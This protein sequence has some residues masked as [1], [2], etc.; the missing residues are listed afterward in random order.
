MKFR[1]PGQ[2]IGFLGGGQL[3][4]MMALHAHQLGFQ[5]H[6]LCQSALEPAAQVTPHWHQGYPNNFEDLEKFLKKIDF[7]TCESEF[8]KGDVLKKAS[9]S[10]KAPL[11]PSPEIMSEL[12]DRWT[13]KKS[14]EEF[15][16]PTAPFF[17]INDT[18][19]FETACNF[20]KHKLVFKK[21]HGGYDGNGTYI[22]KSKKNK[23]KILTQLSE[24]NFHVI[25]EAFIPFRRELA[26]V[27]VR[28]QFGAILNLPL[29]ETYQKNSRCDWVRGPAKHG[30]WV[31]IK[32]RIEAWLE[33]KNYVGAIA[34]EFFDTGKNLLINESAPR[35]HN[36]GHY[37]E[38]ALEFSQFELH[39]RAVAGLPLPQENKLLSPQFVMVNLLGESEQDVEFPKNHAGYLHWYGKDQNH[40]G[41]KMGHLNFLGKNS[42]QLLKYALKERKR[43]KL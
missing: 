34:F 3:A 6:V 25:A 30:A 10:T 31:K 29:V 8:Y 37:S 22:L 42:N 38:Q 28:D 39:V 35:V 13:Q 14:F 20:F 15:G 11:F 23:E 4:R 19:S 18:D 36:S 24:I 26:A 21:R 17:L 9:A 43:M 40:K 32:T 5:V 41:R 27:F 33:E 7:A 2:K 1:K 16:L 12:Q